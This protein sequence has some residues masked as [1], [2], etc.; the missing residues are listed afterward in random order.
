MRKFP[1]SARRPARGGKLGKLLLL[2]PIALE[3]VS[4]LRNQ[5]RAKRGKYHRASRRGKAFDFA[6]SQAKRSLGKGK[7][8][9]FF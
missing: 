5:Q 7:R 3:I 9:G 6:L 2:A 8:R 4:H 1:S